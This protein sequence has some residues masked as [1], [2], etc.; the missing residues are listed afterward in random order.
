[1]E[2]V[3]DRKIGFISY[4]EDH[5]IS[6][7]EILYFIRGVKKYSNY[8]TTN[9]LSQIYAKLMWLKCNHPD[10]YESRLGKEFDLDKFMNSSEQ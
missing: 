1:M 5:V 4:G 10:V 9:V 8:D 2:P 7:N 3:T 6:G